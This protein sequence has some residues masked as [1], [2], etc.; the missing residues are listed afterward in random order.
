METLTPPEAHMHARKPIGVGFLGAG[1]VTQAIHLPT[2]SRLADQ[3]QIAH[4]MDVDARTASQLA[5]SVGARHSTSVDDLLA[6]PNVDVVAVCSPHKYHAA[7]VMAA[8]RAGKKAILCEKPLAV[9]A[10]E[11]A[12]I[13]R[14]A[15]ETGVPIIVGAMHSFDPGWKAAELMFEDLPDTAHTLLSSITLPANERFEDF[16]TQVSGRL[17]PPPPDLSTPQGIAEAL[18]T[19]ILSLAVNDLP[20]VRR[21]VPSFENLQVLHAEVVC[22]YGYLILVRAGGR[23]IHLTASMTSTWKPAWTFEAIGT[24]SSLKVQFTP[25]YVQ[26]GSAV[27]HYTRGSQTAVS[28]PSDS[29]GYEGEWRLIAD[30][31][32][33]LQ[34]APEMNGLVDD[35]HFAFSI[36]EGA[37]NYVLESAQ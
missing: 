27:A 31:V 33:G 9:S 23:T 15:T 26:A 3:F 28:G 19:A 11:S 30:I 32:T 24:E 12:N 7:Q 4:V 18:N 6:D 34:P 37:R 20:L 14:V 17:T 16:A 5:D 36:A 25:S 8:C 1:P 29:N 13:A 10:E 35:L 21:F 2:L 22:P